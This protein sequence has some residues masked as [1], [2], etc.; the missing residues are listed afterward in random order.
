MS[1]SGIN[2]ENMANGSKGDYAYTIVETKEKV[3]DETVA[4]IENNADF[5]RVRNI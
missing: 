1:A 2:I 4:L 3:K 5:I